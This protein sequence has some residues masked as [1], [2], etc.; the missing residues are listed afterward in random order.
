MI[1][2]IH[3][4]TPAFIYSN[5]ELFNE[6]TKGPRGVMSPA[7][8]E[9]NIHRVFIAEIAA[10][11]AG[12]A[13]VTSDSYLPSVFVHPRYRNRGIGR[14]LLKRVGPIAKKL[15]LLNWDSQKNLCAQ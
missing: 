8:K 1:L 11:C 4:V 9:K 2:M 14:K 15:I 6:L 12:W 5:F 10:E 3:E 7:I 13:I